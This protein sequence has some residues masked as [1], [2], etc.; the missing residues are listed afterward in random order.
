MQVPERVDQLYKTGQNRCEK[1]LIL[2]TTVKLCL[3]EI[4]LPLLDVISEGCAILHI[5]PRQF[6]ANLTIIRLDRLYSS[7]ARPSQYM[8]KALLGE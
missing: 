3:L 6:G 1:V 2:E 8:C 5:L 4:F 7:L